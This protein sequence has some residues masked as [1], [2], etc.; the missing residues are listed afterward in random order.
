MAEVE[1]FVMPS[2]GVSHLIHRLSKCTVVVTRASK[3]PLQ[4]WISLWS[5]SCFVIGRAGFEVYSSLSR[6][7][8]YE[9]GL[10][11]VAC[12]HCGCSD[13]RNLVRR[14]CDL[15]E[16]TRHAPGHRRCPLATRVRVCDPSPGHASKPRI[17]NR[18]FSPE[19]SPGGNLP[20]PSLH[21]WSN[22]LICVRHGRY[23][24]SCICG[25]E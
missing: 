21:C 13:G 3:T 17:R 12:R 23:A 14:H 24:D 25:R 8:A 18:Q 9:A 22:G 1:Q 5:T 10:P 4:I 19:L 11:V 2:P 20:E 16:L 7:R 15:A 6:P